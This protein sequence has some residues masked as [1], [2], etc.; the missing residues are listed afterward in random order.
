MPKTRIGDERLRDGRSLID[1]LERRGI[2]IGAA[3]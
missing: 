3:F 1:D 2:K